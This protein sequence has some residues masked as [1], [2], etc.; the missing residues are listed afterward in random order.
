MVEV[1]W[2]LIEAEVFRN[3]V[4]APRLGL[5]LKGAKHHFA[6]VFLVVGALVRHAQHRH[7]GQAFNRFC[8]DVEVL[9]GVQRNRHAGHVGEVTR[10]HART[11]HH[12]VCIDGAWLAVALVIYAG[13]R[14][15]RL[16]DA[17]DFDVLNDRCTH[18]TRAFGQ[19]QSDVC[20]VT[21]TVER[22]VNRRRHT[23]DV[24]VRIHG[25]G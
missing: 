15:V 13:H 17:R 16:V 10:P 4:H 22:Q 2:Q 21:L 18:L 11:V 25:Q 7:L 23:V 24:Q 1:F 3:A 20:R 6:R 14:A 8:H 5:G 19:G 9:T 12:D